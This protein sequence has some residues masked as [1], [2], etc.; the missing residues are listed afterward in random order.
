MS[1]QDYCGEDLCRHS[2][3]V[4]GP[5]PEWPS[6]SSQN[7]YA[8]NPME[9][10]KDLFR[11]AEGDN[12]LLHRDLRISPKQSTGVT[13]RVAQFWETRRNKDTQYSGLK[14]ALREIRGEISKLPEE[15]RKNR[16]G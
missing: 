1:L 14:K 8:E 10:L 6:G 9:R 11:V 13:G 3:P 16:D 2:L 4:S 5:I 15:E 7:R 12:V